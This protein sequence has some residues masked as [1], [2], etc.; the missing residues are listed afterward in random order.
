M[1]YLMDTIE[2]E[3]TYYIRLWVLDQSAN[4]SELSFGCTIYTRVSPGPITNLVA[5][6]GILGR[7]IRLTWSAPGDDWYTGA[8]RPGSA[9]AIQR[10]TWSEIEWSTSTVDNVYISTQTSQPGEDQLSTLTSLLA[11]TTYYVRVWTADRRGN[12]SPISNGATAW[13][14]YVV[15]SVDLVEPT[16]WYDFGDVATNVSTVSASGLM[17]RNDGNVHET[18]S[19]RITTGT[20]PPANTVWTSSTTVGYDLFVLYGL[21]KDQQPDASAFDDAD[22]ILTLDPQRASA[23]QFSDGSRTG[24]GV[25]P[26]LLDPLSSDTMLWFKL[27]TPLATSTTDQQTIPVVI[28]A[29]ESE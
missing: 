7:S 20:E 17:V 26:Y 15:L 6:T 4:W 11:G 24:V 25:R 18:Y 19:L 10:S 5:Y 22:D 13:A 12:W 28:T 3:T 29:E 21:F 1:G 23:S 9:Y 14:Q 8:L 2:E 16:T 27:R